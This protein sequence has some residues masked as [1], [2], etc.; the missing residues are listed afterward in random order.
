M[1]VT[2]NRTHVFRRPTE[3]SRSGQGAAWLHLSAM[4]LVWLMAL[5]I[6][7]LLVLA[8]AVAHPLRPR[9]EMP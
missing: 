1:P 3:G 7:P 4:G 2:P 8:A 5:P 6:T 9:R